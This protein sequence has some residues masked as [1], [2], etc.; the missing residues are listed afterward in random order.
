MVRRERHAVV[1]QVADVVAALERAAGRGQDRVLHRGLDAL[2]HAADEVPAVLRRAEA[3]IGARPQH[4]HLVAAR[5]GVRVLHRLGRA[6]P[7][8]VGDRE[9]DVRTLADEGLGDRLAGGLAGEVAGEAAVLGPL[10]PAEH[11]DVRVVLGVVV[12]DA[13]PEAVH[14]DGDRGQLLTAVRR[15]LAGLG[16]ARGQVATEEG[17][18]RGVEQQRVD[19]RDRRIVGIVHDRE[20]LLRVGRGGGLCVVTH[21]EPDRDDDPAL[22]AEEPVDVRC[23]LAGGL[24]LQVGAGDLTGFRGHRLLDPLPGRRVDRAVAD[25]AGVGDQAGLER[26]RRRRAA[27]RRP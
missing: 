3:A 18:L 8:V 23:V 4:V 1:R 16:H 19:V 14:V 7:D 6:E 5:R 25:A 13:V 17:V 10:V 11:R 9:D 21:Q 27:A 22:L 12:L 26:A 15:D 2:G 24:G 20:L